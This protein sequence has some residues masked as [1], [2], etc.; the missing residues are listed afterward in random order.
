VSA[1]DH[2]GADVHARRVELDAELRPSFV[3]DTPWGSGK[4]QLAVRGEHQVLNAAL[5]ATVALER[6]VGFDDVVA[7]LA[8]AQ[9]ARWR[10][11]VVRAASGLLVLD[12]SYNANPASMAAGLR[13]LA[14]LDVPGRRV[15]VLGEMRELGGSSATEHAAIGE[16]VAELAVDML[17]AVGPEAEPMAAAARERGIDTLAAPDAASALAAVSARVD[18]RDAVLVKG[19]RAV[20]LELVAAGLTG[21]NA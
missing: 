17:V 14:R 10:M 19:S 8:T 18:A 20:G 16:L 7:G 5:A 1:A 11:E 3:L 6:G 12:D 15:A 9:P 13:A 4:V 2:A 21:T